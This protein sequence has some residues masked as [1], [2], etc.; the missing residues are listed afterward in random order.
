MNHWILARKSA[1]R[2]F[3]ALVLGMGLITQVLAEMTDIEH[4][5]VI[6]RACDAAIW[7]MPAVGIYDIELAIQRDAGARPGVV[8]YMSEPMDSRHGFL[9]ANDVTPYVFTGLSVKDG[10]IVI[11]VPPAGDKAAFFGTIVNAWQV[12]I[13]DVGVAGDDQGKG[14]KYLILPPGYKGE[15]HCC[16]R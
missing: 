11:E 15:H 7:S 6:R 1:Y 10:P 3:A 14:G 13:A 5:T 9:T 12:P 4:Q 2:S 8:A 16:P